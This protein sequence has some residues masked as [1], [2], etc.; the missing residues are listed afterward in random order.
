MKILL[1]ILI[2][3]FVLTAC[4]RQSHSGRRA[5]EKE[6]TTVATPENLEKVVILDGVSGVNINGV[7]HYKYK[8]CRIE[9]DSVS[10]YIYEKN[11]YDVS[12]KILVRQKQFVR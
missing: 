11:L 2:S 9:K 10:D 4:E 7:F 1:M 6:R 3:V 12:D 5:L 8:V